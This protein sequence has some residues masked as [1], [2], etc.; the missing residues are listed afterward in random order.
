MSTDYIDDVTGVTEKSKQEFDSQVWTEKNH[1]T[2]INECSQRRPSILY[3][4][5]RHHQSL[6]LSA[7]GKVPVDLQS[8]LRKYD[9]LSKNYEKLGITFETLSNPIIVFR[10]VAARSIMSIMNLCLFEADENERSVFF[11]CYSPNVLIK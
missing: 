9:L 5:R 8:E 6:I 1:K 10:H 2:L 11:I 7:A 3:P 4:N